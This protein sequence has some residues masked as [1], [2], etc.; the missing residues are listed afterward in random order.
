MH[1]STVA[2]AMQTRAAN[3]WLY[4]RSSVSPLTWSMM[5]LNF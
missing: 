3:H 5:Y 1:A 2:R 4:E